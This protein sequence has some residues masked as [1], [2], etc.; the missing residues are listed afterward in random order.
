MNDER[1]KD[2]CQGAICPHW[3]DGNCHIRRTSWFSPRGG[4]PYPVDDCA[5]TRTLLMVRDL[6]AR[7]DAIET[8]LEQRNSELAAVTSRLDQILQVLR[9]GEIAKRMRAEV[10]ADI[11]KQPSLI[12][13]EE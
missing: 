8:V 3:A 6:H 9:M 4:E 5:P 2:T 13:G 1:Q 7:M 12:R 11:N 10:L